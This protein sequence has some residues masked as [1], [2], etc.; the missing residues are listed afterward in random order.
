MSLLALGAFAVIIGPVVFWGY[1][2]NHG[3]PGHFL[4]F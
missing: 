3:T 4:G 2:L 1:L